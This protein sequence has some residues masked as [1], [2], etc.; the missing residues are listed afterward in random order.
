MQSSRIKTK[1]V[2]CIEKKRARDR[3]AQENLRAK[4]NSQ[5]EALQASICTLDKRCGALES[6]VQMLRRENEML[7]AF[8]DRN[9]QLVEVDICPL[10]EYGSSRVPVLSD[11]AT[12]LMSDLPGPEID[13]SII[14]IS[15]TQIWSQPLPLGFTYP[16]TAGFCP[17]S[18]WGMVPT[19][20]RTYDFFFEDFNALITQPELV[21]F[22]PESPLAVD[23]LF[24]SSTNALANLIHA[25]TRFWPCGEPERLAGDYWHMKLL[26]GC[27][28]LRMA[29]LRAYGTSRSPCQSSSADLTH[30]VL[31]LSHGLRSVPIWSR[32][33]TCT[34]SATSWVSLAAVS[35]FGGLGVLISSSATT[36]MDYA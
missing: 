26:G 34:I 23:L 7:R 12:I 2:G 20:T 21:L 30:S 14:D 9:R 32:N 31:I 22:A 13:T 3:R 17:P 18:P 24:G 35:R 15:R 28:N 10:P 29:G 6:E 25:A 11:S 8:R 1:S 36:K 27:H 5:L 16:A 4:R 33:I 19:A